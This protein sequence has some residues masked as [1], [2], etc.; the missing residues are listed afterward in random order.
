MHSVLGLYIGRG[1]GIQNTTK[2]GDASVIYDVTDL[3]FYCHEEEPPTLAS[4]ACNL[5]L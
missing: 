4:I 3:E 5:S 1:G 2:I